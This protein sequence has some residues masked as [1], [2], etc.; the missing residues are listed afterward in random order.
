MANASGS[1]LAHPDV[2]ADEPVGDVFAEPEPFTQELGPLAD[3]VAQ[4]GEPHP[5]GVELG[6]QGEHAFG[7]PV[8]LAVLVVRRAIGAGACP[9]VRGGHLAETAFPVQLGDFG[10]VEYAAVAA[11]VGHEQVADVVGA[12]VQ[13]PH[14]V[15]HDD[16]DRV[17]VEG[18]GCGD[19][20]GHVSDGTEHPCE[21][22]R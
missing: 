8:V 3:V 4:A 21:R 17:A 16:V 19:R 14:G 20:V 1:G 15:E 2:P 5:G 13:D 7:Q 9:E 22:H 12:R 11:Q 6:E 18:C 10:P